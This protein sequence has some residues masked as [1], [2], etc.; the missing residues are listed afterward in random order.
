[1][2]VAVLP[3][4]AVSVYVLH[5]VDKDRV[6]RWNLAFLELCEEF[7]IFSALATGLFLL[8]LW[9]GR[10]LLRKP[11]PPSYFFCL[12]PWRRRDF[13]SVSD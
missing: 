13:G 4:N 9:A 5:D 1:M 2:L 8:F 12:F 6:G 3:V 11:L 10:A 7:L